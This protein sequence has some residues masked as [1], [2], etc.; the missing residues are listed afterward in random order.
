VLSQAISRLRSATCIAGS[1]SSARW[2][3]AIASS[4]IPLL[5]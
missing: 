3:W 1:I 4:A 5:K 2:N